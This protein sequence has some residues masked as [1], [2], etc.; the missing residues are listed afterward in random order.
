MAH[1][2][3]HLHHDN[4]LD[5]LQIIACKSGVHLNKHLITN[6]LSLH[7]M[8]KVTDLEESWQ[9]SRN[10]YFVLKG[11]LQLYEQRIAER[12][13]KFNTQPINHYRNFEDEEQKYSSVEE[14]RKCNPDYFLIEEIEEFRGVG[15]L[16]GEGRGGEFR[17]KLVAVDAVL[18]VLGESEHATESVVH[19]GIAH[20]D[21]L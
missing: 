11:C 9:K 5:L 14:F 3:E 1:R 2:K 6:H 19:D 13:L 7:F 4:K 10:S 17:L 21:K 16:F 18:A 8:P 12:Q 20:E 15:E